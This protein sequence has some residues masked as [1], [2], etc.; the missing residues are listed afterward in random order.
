M[1][2]MGK[3]RKKTQFPS[4]YFAKPSLQ[5]WPKIMAKTAKN[6]VVLDT[7]SNVQPI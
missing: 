5:S 1:C 2:D 6:G 4:N 3:K 7:T